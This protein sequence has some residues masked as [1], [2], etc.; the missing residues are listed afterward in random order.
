MRQVSNILMA[1][2]VVSAL[3]FGNCLSCPQ[4]LMAI[5]GHQP[6]HGCCHH[7]TAK[8]DCHSQALSHF[9]KAQGANATPAFAASGLAPAVAA[10]TTLARPAIAPWRVADVAPPD[11]LSLHSLLRV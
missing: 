4:M 10:V 9:V 11:L 8:I 1:A 3:F 2:L 7:P 5:A 6:G